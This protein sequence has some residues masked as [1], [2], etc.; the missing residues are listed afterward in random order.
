LEKGKVTL[1]RDYTEVDDTDQKIIPTE[2][3][4]KAY[5]YG[6]QLVP[7]SEENEAVLKGKIAPP[8]PKVLPNGNSQGNHHATSQS[9]DNRHV[10]PEDIAMG[11]NGDVEKQFKIL[12]FTD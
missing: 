8:K 11:V 3:Q 4:R 10:A 12:G 7:V 2:Q 9:D 1:Q 6:K 5:F